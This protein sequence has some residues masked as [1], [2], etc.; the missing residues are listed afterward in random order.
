MKT[1]KATV[2]LIIIVCTKLAFGQIDSS[3]VY[4]SLDDFKLRKL[5]YAINCKTEKHKIKKTN[6]IDHEFIKVIHNDR[7]YALKKNE[8]FGYLDCKV[9]T[10]RF[11]DR[12]TYFILNPTEDILIYRHEVRQPKRT[13]TH[14]LFSR[15]LDNP[16]LKLTKENLKEA[17]SDNAEFKKKIDKVFKKDTQLT[18]Y[19][20][21]HKIYAIN[22]LLKEANVS[23]ISK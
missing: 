1:L 10:Y 7:A 18:R 2:I 20:R 19:N 15:G 14:Y 3:G 16:P 23:M 17:F 22:W 13:G 4:L 9:G 5:A 8:I 12:K 11:I 6:L 21:P